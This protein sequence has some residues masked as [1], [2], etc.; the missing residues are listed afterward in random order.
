[1]EDIVKG[2]MTET[3]SILGFIEEQGVDQNV[4]KSII[5]D[6]YKAYCDDIGTKTTEDGCLD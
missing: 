2:Y 1:M 4:D 3:D 5:Y 6:S